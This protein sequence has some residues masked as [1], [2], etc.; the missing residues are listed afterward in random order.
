MI[1]IRKLNETFFELYARL[2]ENGEDLTKRQRD[3]MSKYLLEQYE[4]EYKK[5][6]LAKEIDDKKE[7][8]NV[9]LLKSFYLP[10]KFLFF[11]N[12]ISKLMALEVKKQAEDYFNT[13]SNKINE[14]K[15]K[16]RKK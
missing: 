9:K 14:T 8:Y 16:E 13:Y 6:A 3:V 7:I 2:G 1:R 15:N 5:I 10:F 12:K 4:I 11:R